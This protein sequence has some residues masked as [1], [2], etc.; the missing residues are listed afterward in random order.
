LEAYKK[1]QAVVVSNA[2]VL[3]E[4]QK[5]TE[6]D[7][8]CS[9]TPSTKQPHGK[10]ETPEDKSIFFTS[11]NSKMLDCNSAG[12]TGTIVYVTYCTKTDTMF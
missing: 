7:E 11:S 10:D 12:A 6:Y 4:S 3:P 5:Q 8:S 2:D 1:K 9:P